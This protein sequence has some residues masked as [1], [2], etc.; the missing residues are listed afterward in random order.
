[1]MKRSLL[2]LAIAAATS[3]SLMAAPFLPMD[4]RGLAMGNTGVASA[5]L[6]HAP[7]YN[8]SL[9][10]QARDNDDFAILFPQIGV[11]V[12]DE[13]ELIN[14]AELISD[15]IFPA[16]ERAIDGDV[17]LTGLNTSLDNLNNA[18]D[19]LNDAIDEVDA[20]DISG[21]LSALQAANTNVN[22]ALTDTQTNLGALNSSV[23]DLTRS[24]GGI[25]GSPLSARLGAGG[26]IAIPSKRFAT[27]FSIQGNAN[28]SARAN[29]SRGDLN[30][31]NAYPEAA[32]DYVTQVTNTSNALTTALGIVE[33][34][35]DPTVKANQL[36]TALTNAETSLTNLETYNNS[37]ILD[38]G[39]QF[40]IFIEGEFVGEDPNLTSTLQVVAVSVVDFAV[41]FSREFDIKGEKVAIGITPKLQKISTFHYADEIDSFDEVDS[42]TVEDS[43]KDYSSFNLDIGASYRFGESDKWMVGVVGKNLLGGDYDYA[44][45]WVTPKNSDGIATGVPYRLKGGTVSLAPQFRAGVAYNGDWTSVAFDLDLVENDS[46]AF[47]S[48]TQYAAIGAEFDVFR[49]LQLRV[50]YRTNLSASDQSVVSAGIGISPFGLHID[51][52]AMVNPSDVEKEA[53]IALETGFYF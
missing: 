2:T 20:S 49:S 23:S 39:S 36:N 25:S 47:E 16:F 42:D 18:L 43:R 29:F 44:D 27:A 34:E 51:I 17:N 4:A 24:L 10:S 38:D 41:S 9:L 40:D 37:V 30:L 46:V 19:D 12:A 11:T 52:A 50:G 35:S 26:A 48:A 13:K 3:P 53:G 5:R 31:L 14:E 8:P 21:S 1:M 7:A 15:D 28:I 45:V 6:A 33:S 22:T 32:L